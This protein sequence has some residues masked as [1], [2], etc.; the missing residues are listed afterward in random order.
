MAR[1]TLRSS[2]SNAKIWSNKGELFTR[3]TSGEIGILPHHIPMVAQ[4]V[5]DAVVRVEQEGEDDLR[6]AVHGGFMS[7]TSRVKDPRRGRR[8]RV[9]DRRGRGQGGCR[10]DDPRD[11]RSRPGASAA[12]W[13]N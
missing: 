11:R 3:T 6:I 9:R 2:P 1:W 5:D 13:V 4:L 8:V 10:L 7:V 12:R